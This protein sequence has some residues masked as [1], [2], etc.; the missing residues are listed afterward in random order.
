V[1]PKASERPVMTMITATS[2]ATGPSIEARIRLK[3]ASRG[4]SE[5]AASAGSA[6]PGTSPATKVSTPAEKTRGGARRTRHALRPDRPGNEADIR[7]FSTE[8]EEVLLFS[9]LVNDFRPAC[10][11]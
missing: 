3:G 7:L 5:P 11:Q 10:V 6:R 9:I 2:R 8:S 4:M 1:S